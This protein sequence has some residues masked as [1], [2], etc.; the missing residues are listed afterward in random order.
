MT[1]LQ[2]NQSLWTL[3]KGVATPGHFKDGTTGR[4]CFRVTPCLQSQ[5]DI[6]PD[7]CGV[8]A[9]TCH[10]LPDAL[11]Q[12]SSLNKINAKSLEHGLRVGAP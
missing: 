7:A 1:R 2:R 10:V 3:S 4:N 11:L 8:K 12:E 5:S 9:T 6:S